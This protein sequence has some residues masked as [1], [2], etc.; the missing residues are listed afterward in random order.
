LGTALFTT[1]GT[2]LFSVDTLLTQESIDKIIQYHREYP[3]DE[4]VY[5]KA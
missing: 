5:I 3:V 1:T 2:K 4:T